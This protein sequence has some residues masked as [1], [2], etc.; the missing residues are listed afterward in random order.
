MRFLSR[1]LR[2]SVQVSWNENFYKTGWSSV[3][4]PVIQEEICFLMQIR[5]LWYWWKKLLFDLYHVLPC[6]EEIEIIPAV[7][8]HLS[9]SVSLLPVP[10]FPCPYSS[11]FCCLS[12]PFAIEFPPGNSIEMT[13]LQQKTREIIWEWV[14]L[15]TSNSG[16]SLDT[17]LL[18]KRS[19]PLQEANV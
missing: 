18:I 19:K 16:R 5:K 15:Y 14:S 4:K 8:C 9:I 11:A 13:F 3:Y 12:L 10:S 6:L 7:F 2:G 17:R 1:Y